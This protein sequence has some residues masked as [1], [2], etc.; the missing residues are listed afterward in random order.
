M[1]AAEAPADEAEDHPWRTLAPFTFS[2]KA[3]EKRA[4]QYRE[5][6]AAEEAQDAAAQE[7]ADNSPTSELGDCIEALVSQLEREVLLR[8]S[9]S[10]APGDAGA[11]AA[12][13][14]VA[15]GGGGG[16]DFGEGGG[17]EESRAAK[18]ALIEIAVEA[19]WRRVYA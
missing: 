3:V 15:A 2:R 8:T 7:L 19:I 17:G 13:A 4:K 16:S 11:A 5:Q 6:M 18:R 12:A 10:T 14:P 1:A 9:G